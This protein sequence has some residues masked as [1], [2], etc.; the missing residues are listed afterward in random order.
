[1]LTSFCVLGDLSLLP[2]VVDRAFERSIEEVKF[3][4]NCIRGEAL[5][6]YK[7]RA[8]GIRRAAVGP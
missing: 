3:H 1:M 8:T 2:S 4:V 7:L 6:S 5:E